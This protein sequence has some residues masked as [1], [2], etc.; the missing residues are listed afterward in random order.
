MSTWSSITAKSLII[1]SITWWVSGNFSRINSILDIISKSFDLLCWNIIGIA[2]IRWK[3]IWSSVKYFEK[4]GSNS[5]RNYSLLKNQ[6]NLWVSDNIFINKG[7]VDII[8]FKKSIINDDILF[9]PCL[10]SNFIRVSATSRLLLLEINKTNPHSK[11][12]LRSSNTLIFIKLL[13]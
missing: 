13:L 10:I 11:N 7:L 5:L 3:F 6:W 1:L 9:R 8:Y 4:K 2:L 12:L